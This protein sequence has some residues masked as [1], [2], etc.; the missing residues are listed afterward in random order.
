MDAPHLRCAALCPPPIFQAGR[1]RAR[2]STHGYARGVGNRAKHRVS[3]HRGRHISGLVLR[4][5]ERAPCFVGSARGG[6]PC[7]ATRD[8]CIA[9]DALDRRFGYRLVVVR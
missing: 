9:A 7:L 5:A 6:G 4:D 1:F 8:R 2:A 3:L